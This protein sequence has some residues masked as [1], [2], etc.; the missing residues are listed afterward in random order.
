MSASLPIVQTRLPHGL[1]ESQDER[2]HTHDL[3]VI[4]VGAG[5]AGLSA[6]QMLGRAGRRTLVV[7][8]GAG[9]NRFATRM[10]GVL[11]LDG[12]TPAELRARGRAEA[13]AY[14]VE[15]RD[16]AVES[17]SEI[18]GDAD[19]GG[20]L[21]VTFADA[22]P[23][24]TRA[25]IAATGVID[26]LP[27]VPG[28][29]ERWGRT[30]LH[31]PYCHGWEVRGRRLGVLATSPLSLHQIELIRQWSPDLTA[32]TADLG[33]LDDVTRERLRARGIR[34]VASPVTEV[35]G[36]DAD[37]S[38]ANGGISA[39]RTADGALVPL[40]A[41]FTAAP[42][43]LR[44]DYLAGLALARSETPVGDAI[45]AD[46]MGRTSHP[47]VWA[48]GNL[49]SPMANVPL[50]MGMGSMAGASANA[51]L[52]AEDADA[53]VAGRRRHAAEWEA[54]YADSDRVWSGRV[55]ATTASVIA[56]VGPGTAVDIGCGEGG[57]AVWLAERGWQST[58]VDLSPTAVARARA[59]AAERG[60]D[61]TFVAGDLDDL[62]ALGLEPGS[63]DLVTTSFLHSWDPEFS[64]IR[65]LR[66]AATLVAPGGLLLSVSHAAAP[67]WS[68]GHHQG[69]PLAS[70]SEE[71]AA[72]DLDPA[73]WQVEIEEVRPRT[74]TGPDGQPADLDDGVLLLRRQG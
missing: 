17:V 60:L 31:C 25:L 3:D 48:A 63:F 19:S 59:A 28:L 15:F 21:T 38:P 67:P 35:V 36:P 73:E 46:A 13:E 14:G 6:A 50:S 8:T 1:G 54:R 4:I 39:V 44:D 66:R 58:G 30:V 55:N 2:M 56:S 69:P 42:V 72:L 23:L 37:G 62:D 43:R 7:D 27:D 47:R 70:P 18:T 49:V 9:R 34:L 33:D 24:T 65:L 26:E 53:A 22:P 11:G 40:D 61:A 10:H 41:I 45:A 29:A 32:F 20:G 12:T 5:P 16:A 71:R 57:D 51:V 68:A 74:V 52:V 64:R